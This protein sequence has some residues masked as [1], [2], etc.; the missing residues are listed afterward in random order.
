MTLIANVFC[1][2]ETPKKVIREMSEKSR[3]REPLHKK[4]GKRSQTVLESGRQQL[5]HIC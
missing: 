5:Y 2:L 1:K 4:H 3:F